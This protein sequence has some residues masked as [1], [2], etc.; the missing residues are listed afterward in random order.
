VRFC[1]LRLVDE[2]DWHFEVAFKYGGRENTREG[3]PACPA[4]GEGLDDGTCI[5]RG[6][7]N[8]QHTKM[9]KEQQNIL[10]TVRIRTSAKGN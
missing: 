8:E 4:W 5:R 9:G 7:Y 3:P 10:G 2:R 6:N 1:L